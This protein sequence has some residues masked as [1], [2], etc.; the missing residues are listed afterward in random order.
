[1]Q[2]RYEVRLFLATLVA[3]LIVSMVVALPALG[4]S[5]NAGTIV[6]TI[7]DPSGAI[8][9]GA[10]VTITDTATGV[11]RTTNTNDAGHY[12][13]VNVTPGK[14]TLVVSKQG[15]SNMTT[16]LEVQV[17]SST[18]ADL[19]L[20]IGGASVTVE[21]QA[22]ANQL[23]TLNS[24][25]G[26]TV[27]SSALENLPTLGRD[28]SSF[29]TLQPGVS[30]DG[31]AAGTVVDQTA[32]MLDGGSNSNDMDGSSG[33]YNPNFGD[34]PAGGLFSNKNNQISGINLGINGGQPSG[35]MP[36]PVDSV[37]EFKVATT[38]QTADVN[39]SSGMQ[40]SIV[41]KRGTSA[42]HGTVY[43]YYLDNNFSA[44]TWEN[45]QST[46]ITPVPDW[47]RNWFGVAVGGPI[48]PKEILGGKT[49]FFF[50]YQGARWPNSETV[51][52]L[53]PSADMRTGILHDPA[54]PTTTSYNLNI[55][56]PRTVG[57]TP[58][59]M[60]TYVQQL[61][62]KY[63]PL[64]TPGAGCSSLTND[65]FCDG[66][67]TLAFRANMAIPQNDNF[68]VVRLD[69]DFGQKWHFMSSYRYYHLTRA[70][71]DQIDIGGFFSGDKLG[72]PASLTNRPQVPW[73]LVLGLTTNVTPQI[74]ND[75]HYSF[76]RN[77]WQWGSHGDPAQFSNLGA[78]LEPFGEQRDDVAAPYNVNTQ[79]TRTRFWNG[80]DNFLRDDVSWLK[81]NH[82]L[83]FGGQ[84]QHNWNYHQRTDNGGGI[85][86]YPVYQL[87]DT[88]GSG[89][90]DMTCG[91]TCL[92]SLFSTPPLSREAAAVLG[93]V[94][95]TQ[96]AYT[97]SGSN[98]TLN[99]P[100]VP[101][102]DKVTIPYYNLYFNDTWHMKPSIT[103]TY[104]LGWA[105]EM[106]P[107]EQTG[108]QVMFVG[109][110]GQEL[111][112]QTYLAQRKA[113]AL[114]G[115]VYNPQIGF[116]LIG[117]VTPRPNYEYDPLYHAF[118][119]RIAV[120]WNPDLGEKLGGKN[121]VFRGGYGRIYGRLNG[122]G[123]VLGPLLSPGLIQPV[124]CSFVLST[125]PPDG[126]CASSG[127]T[128]TNAFR[129]GTDGTSAY[130]PPASQ[131][132]PQPFDPGVN[133]N[134]PAATAS[135]TDPKFRPN[136][137]DSFDFTI[138][139]QFSSKISLELG[140]IS[141]WIHNELL[142]VNL[143]SVPHMMTLG[144]QRFDAAYANIEAAMGCTTSLA[145]CQAATPA[146]LSG[147]A[148][149]PFFEAA[150][151]GTGFCTGFA[152][153]TQ[154]L[155]N[156]PTA[157]PM[158]QSQSV[159]SLWSLLDTGGTAPGFNFP[160]SMMNS[161]SSIAPAG[162][163]ASNVAMTTSLGSGNYNAAFATVKLNDWN[164]V[165]LQNNLTW[166]RALGLGGVVQAT[167]SQAAVDPFNFNV[168]YGTQPSDR[169]IVNT[170]F[171]VYQ[172]PFYSGQHGIVG[173]LL[174]GWTPS[175]VFAA[176]SGASLFCA[177]TSGFPEE[178]YSGAQDFG[179]ADGIYLN[180]DANCVQTV[181]N[182][183]ASVHNV[184]NGT[185]SI[186]A[187]PTAVFNTLRPLVMGADT[188]SGGYGTFRGLPYW[189]LN[190]G[191]K[192]NVRITERFNVEA[193]LSVNNILNHNQLLD[194]TLAA[195]NTPASFGQLS[196]EGTTPRTME[197]GI[198]VN[199]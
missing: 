132:L 81:H 109:P 121:T 51:T 196:I 59:G 163:I 134:S 67:N 170:M 79:Q 6:G 52:K 118:S 53:V 88:L 189:N 87:G 7:I 104:G 148:S 25:I 60:N 38:N 40:V 55:L 122:V 129:I 83:Q 74:T 139:H 85:N 27:T 9:Q 197:M 162:Q 57:G 1:M 99:A 166:S 107:K 39:N 152:N 195:T 82:L 178:G 141:R 98:L 168:Q 32:F 41:T 135:P 62:S 2:V 15:F 77:W 144:G 199:F 8:V 24:T 66:V 90:V 113:A 138:Q 130:I 116:A 17:G 173:H 18:T 20:R 188:R 91:G 46:P 43:E 120:A 21:V 26:N 86:Y 84:Y 125:P 172:E 44:N 63:M 110:S 69:H 155:I 11:T 37:E 30:P 115:Q 106:P 165:T 42:W 10:K 22:A 111:D 126:S 180:T 61:W 133:G 28:T 183:S 127:L 159:F 4:Q 73:Y 45:N 31:S 185:Y 35:V 65:G 151:A 194:P 140:G 146:A 92:N 149:Q 94:T 89:N 105:L 147:L 47:H 103:L 72:T 186:F 137:A 101:A 19:S 93:I 167:S 34:D 198:R 5:T 16:S 70:T 154:A 171:L 142:S 50:N 177:T 181:K 14:Y 71:D 49:Y 48:I 3:L 131:T 96:Q 158:L 75:V 23:Q 114:A 128:A 169:K 97:R 192:K 76:L 176:G 193:S 29:V 102:F 64:P 143:N 187:N 182:S 161:P 153:C 36:T 108:K 12:V 156:N 164:G 174:G 123:L 136:S 13:F 119:P 160:V 112:T 95:D 150:L 175:F 117:N 54:N 100:L 33:V 145:A 179:S 78:A 58:I 191:I 80:R 190:F 157:F 124:S 68:A 184:G 56:D